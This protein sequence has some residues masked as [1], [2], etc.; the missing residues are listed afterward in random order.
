MSL[1]SRVSLPAYSTRKM[2]EKQAMI[3]KDGSIT[4]APDDYEFTEADELPL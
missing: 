4:P 3:E 2:A 1:T